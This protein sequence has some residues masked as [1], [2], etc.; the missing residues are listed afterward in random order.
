MPVPV[1]I[2][3]M[4]QFHSLSGDS[5]Q[6]VKPFL[7]QF[8]GFFL[9]NSALCGNFFPGLPTLLLILLR[10]SLGKHIIPFGLEIDNLQQFFIRQFSFRQMKDRVI[11][12][13]IKHI[14]QGFIRCLFL[15]Q[16]AFRESAPGIGLPQFGVSCLLLLRIFPGVGIRIHSLA[17]HHI[18]QLLLLFRRHL[19]HPFLYKGADPGLY[20]YGR[21]TSGC[22]NTRYN[23]RSSYHRYFF[24]F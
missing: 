3:V 23:G 15:T 11:L 12:C 2:R 17:V 4:I 5:I 20:R 7:S 6:P 8:D 1:R 9:R 19:L 10:G 21:Q 16:F 24:H 14:R 13:I 22:N 18:F